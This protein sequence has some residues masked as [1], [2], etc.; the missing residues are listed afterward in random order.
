MESSDFDPSLMST[1]SSVGKPESSQMMGMMHIG[2][3]ALALGLVGWQCGES[4][5]LDDMMK[6]FESNHTVLLLLLAAVVLWVVKAPMVVQHLVLLAAIAVPAF[7][8][9]L[10]MFPELGEHLGLDKKK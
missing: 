6:C 1:E 7:N 2:A 10:G 3:A 4:K 5:D 8:I 9:I